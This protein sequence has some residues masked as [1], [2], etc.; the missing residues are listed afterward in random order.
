MTRNE[1][2][3]NGFVIIKNV[4][5]KKDINSILKMIAY[6]LNF[7]K[8]KSTKKIEIKS[9]SNKKFKKNS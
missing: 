6:N 3:K 5:P 4:L 9:W 8:K 1:Y 7:F 2:K